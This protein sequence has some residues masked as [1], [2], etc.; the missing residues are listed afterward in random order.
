MSTMAVLLE[1][2]EDQLHHASLATLHAA[3]QRNIPFDVFLMGHNIDTLCQQVASYV[4]VAHVHYTDAANCI[5]PLPEYYAHWAL[6]H[7]KTYTNVLM[8]AS[9][10]GKATLPRIAA[11]LGCQQYSDVIAWHGAHGLKRPMYAGHIEATITLEA[12]QYCFGIRPSAF[13]GMPAQ[14]ATRA[15]LSSQ[16]IGPAWT[17]TRRH[18]DT[19]TTKEGPSLA[20]AEIVLGGG[21]GLGSADAF[22]QLQALATSWGAAVGASRAAVDAGFM[23]NEYQIG[24]TGQIIAPKLYIAIGISG[25]IQHIAGIMDSQTIVAINTDPDAPIFQISDYKIV[26][27]WQDALPQL[28]HALQ[29]QGYLSQSCAST[30]E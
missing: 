9:T 18:T 13:Q 17:K 21:R 14:H 30:S 11:Q 19:I 23:P 5:A 28:Q 26:M 2:V 1:C 7:L 6:P 16:P 4:G 22:A 15:P 10:W 8:G 3:Q 24:Q 20:T 12:G 27:R 25:A 29:A